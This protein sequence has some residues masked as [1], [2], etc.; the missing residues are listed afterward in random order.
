MS[1][2]SDVTGCFTHKNGLSYASKH[3]KVNM[4]RYL[5]KLSNAKLEYNIDILCIILKVID[6]SI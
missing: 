5:C 3:G 6:A 1:Q 4:C 2:F